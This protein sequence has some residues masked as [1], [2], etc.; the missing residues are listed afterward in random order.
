MRESSL[1]VCSAVLLAWLLGWNPPLPALAYDPASYS[2]ANIHRG[3]QPKLV[4]IFGAGGPKGLESYQSG[5][6]VSEAGHIVTSWSTVLDVSA[7]RVVLYDGSKEDAEVIG[8]DPQTEIAVLKTK[9]AATDFF[10]IDRDD[11]TLNAPRIG[12]RVFGLSNLFKIATGDEDFSIQRGV[13]MAVAPLSAT[14]GRLKTLYQGRVLVLDV[15]TNNPGATGGAVVDSQ[16]NLLGMLG[17]EL[18][19][20][21]TNIWLNY[22]VPLDVISASVR[23]ILEGKT[24]LQ[25]TVNSAKQVENPHRISSLGLM[26]IPDVLPKT[27]PF[28]D[29]V[30]ADSLADR[31]G[32]EANDLVLLVNDQRVD[33]RRSFEELL[34]TLHQADSFSLL[35]QRGQELVRLEVKP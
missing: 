7:L 26:L 34:S 21:Q 11:P 25:S 9:A 15:M 1:R 14:R 19:D 28:V 13:V 35:V 23:R 17:K 12:T 8:M 33:S 5:F 18:R 22:A 27:P 29:Q 6:F 30:L 10:R 31:A 2:M 4:K 24:T 16:G 32:I 3:L 20:D